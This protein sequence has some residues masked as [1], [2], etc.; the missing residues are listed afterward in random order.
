MGLTIGVSRHSV[1]SGEFRVTPRTKARTK[2]LRELKDVFRRYRSQPVG[3]VIYLINPKL[4]GW[5]NYFRIGNST[6]CFS[7]VQNWV[8]MKLRRHLMRARIGWNRWSRE[9]FYESLGLYN[10]YGVRYYRA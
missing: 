10:D 6:E 7:Y 4:R 8:E 3:R 1:A 2:F 9:W 5:V